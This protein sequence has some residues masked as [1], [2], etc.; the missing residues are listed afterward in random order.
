M[1]V[2][3][4]LGEAEKGREGKPGGQGSEGGAGREEKKGS[5][6]SQN[7]ILPL[8]YDCTV[9]TNTWKYLYSNL[10]VIRM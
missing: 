8:D 4:H 6:N 9:L 1:F 2:K 5:K 3:V 10:A 7:Y